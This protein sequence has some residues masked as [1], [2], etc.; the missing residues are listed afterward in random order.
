MGVFW[1]PQD[2]LYLMV[3]DII[4]IDTPWAEKWTETR[5]SFLSA[6]TVTNWLTNWLTNI[7]HHNLL[8]CFLLKT[9]HK[10]LVLFGVERNSSENLKA[11]NPP[12]ILVIFIEHEGHLSDFRQQYSC[13]HFL[14]PVIL[15]SVLYNLPKFS[16][17]T[18]VCLILNNTTNT[19]KTTVATP[20]CS[21]EEL[22]LAP[23][24]I[25]SVHEGHSIILSLKVF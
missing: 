11:K 2:L 5:V 22:R 24:N 6:P 21:L 14:V 10:N 7:V 9:T 19:T 15:Y 8:V 4:E 25:R 3:T 18:T 12:N 13:R 16:E 1:N 23:R 17:F 20:A